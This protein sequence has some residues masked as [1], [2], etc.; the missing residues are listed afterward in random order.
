V[1]RVKV[2]RSGTEV[3]ARTGYC[4]SRPQDLLAGNSTEK[5]LE[6]RAAAAQ[7]GNVSASMQLPYFYTAPNVARVNV[8]MEIATENLKFEKRRANSTPPS[9]FWAWPI[10][11]MVRWARASA[12]P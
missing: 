3:R 5:D 7:A 2:E 10:F 4:N 11:R 9:M 1:L 8:A 12:T 6:T